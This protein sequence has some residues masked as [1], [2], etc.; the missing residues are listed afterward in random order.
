MTQ[1]WVWS[2]LAA[3]SLA[4][5]LVAA[6]MAAQ[7]QERGAGGGRNVGAAPRSA[8]IQAGPARGGAAPLTISPNRTYAGPGYRGRYYA[9]DRGYYYGYDGG[10]FPGLLA[11]PFLLAGGLLGGFGYGYD[12]DYWPGYYGGDYYYPAGYRIS[13]ALGNFCETPQKVCQLISPAEIG[14]G[15]S[16]RAPAGLPRF[17]GAVVP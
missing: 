6:P 3:A 10:W 5:A 13:Y 12:Y 9:G 2:C 4:T 16:C 11:A 17:R 15:C 1:K 7:A 8:A 14:T